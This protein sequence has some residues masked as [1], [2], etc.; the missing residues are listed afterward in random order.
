MK[1]THMRSLVRHLAHR[2]RH[3]RFIEQFF[4]DLRNRTS[5]RGSPRKKGEPL[6]E[7]LVR[8]FAKRLAMIRGT[9]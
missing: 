1:P 7:D 8:Y 3:R 4:G 9:P 2:S 5:P 6:Y